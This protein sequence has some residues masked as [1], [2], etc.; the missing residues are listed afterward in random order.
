MKMLALSIAICFQLA[1]S[2]A[3]GTPTPP[4]FP[5]TFEASLVRTQLWMQP[6]CLYSFH[7]DVQ[8]RHKTSV[9]QQ[10]AYN[11]TL[12][13]ESTVQKDGLTYPVTVWRDNENKRSRMDTFGGRNIMI[14]NKV[15]AFYGGKAS[16][17]PCSDGIRHRAVLYPETTLM[18]LCC[19]LMHQDEE[20][21]VVPRLDR[22][23]CMAEEPDADETSMLDAPVCSHCK[24][25]VMC[26]QAVSVFSYKN[27]CMH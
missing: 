23:V 6:R 8:L 5:S 20:I 25:R 26:K 21:E 17:A 22:L 24:L 27:L 7:E 1:R 10:V 16:A 3:A 9:L 12:P 11:F 19:P 18:S 13:Y 14:T 4:V 15:R 2:S